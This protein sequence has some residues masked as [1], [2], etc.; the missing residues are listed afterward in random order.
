[1]AKSEYNEPGME[2]FEGI[3]SIRLLTILRASAYKVMSVNSTSTFSFLST[4]KYS[5]AVKAMSGISRRSTGGWSVVF[6][7]LMILCRAPALSNWF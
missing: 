5:A 7:K 1:M 4:A 6:T 2:S 3:W